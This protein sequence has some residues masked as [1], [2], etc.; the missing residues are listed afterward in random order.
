MSDEAMKERAELVAWLRSERTWQD[1]INCTKAQDL[2]DVPRICGWI[3]SVI[4]LRG[5]HIKLEGG[6]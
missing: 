1:A 5:L 4:E 6:G 3:A 2:S